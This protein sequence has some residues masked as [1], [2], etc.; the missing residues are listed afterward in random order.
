MSTGFVREPYRFAPFPDRWG[1][2]CGFSSFC[3]V[4]SRRKL[5]R[6][7]GLERAD[8]ILA[9]A[10]RTYGDRLDPAA[11]FFVEQIFDIE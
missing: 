11:R 5:A 1:G 6:E 3:P 9:I 2:F 8:Q 4:V 7:L 10:E